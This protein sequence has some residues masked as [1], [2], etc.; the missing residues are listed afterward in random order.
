MYFQY[1]YFKP[2]VIRKIG[3]VMTLRQVVPSF[4]LAAI[5]VLGIGAFW[6]KLAF[7]VLIFLVGSYLLAIAGVASMVLMKQGP[8]CASWLFAVFPAM[9]FAYGVGFLKGAIRFLLFRRP[10]VKGAAKV[11]ISR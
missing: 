11:P 9:H 10:G 3:R 2:L 4:F 6:S 1:G 5:V 8:A 7:G